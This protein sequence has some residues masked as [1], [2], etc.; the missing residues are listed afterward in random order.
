MALR[1]QPLGRLGGQFG[2]HGGGTW[3]YQ[4]PGTRRALKR[5]PYPPAADRPLPYEN[6]IPTSTLTGGR[7]AR[8]AEHS[9]APARHWDRPTDG[10]AC[11]SSKCSLR[12]DACVEAAGRHQRRRYF[13]GFCCCW[14]RTALQTPAAVEIL[15][16][17]RSCTIHVIPSAIQHRLFSSASKNVFSLL[18][19]L[20]Q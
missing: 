10:A 5:H 14:N 2:V 4:V 20:P 7:I 9:P 16:H 3:V 15:P 13:S 8:L 12:A 11:C 19:L 17:A 18:F 6:L 1:C